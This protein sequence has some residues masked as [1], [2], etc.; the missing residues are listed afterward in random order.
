MVFPEK[1]GYIVQNRR[2]PWKY[3]HTHII[4]YGKDNL[5]KAKHIAFMAYNKMM[6]LH[7]DMRTIQ[8]IIRISV[9]IEYVEKL[10]ALYEEK[11][12]SRHIKQKY[13][14]KAKKG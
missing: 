9:D 1:R 10:K 2:K 3:G 11:S 12:R 8:S 14:N 7:D 5:G 4:T 13:V 6:P